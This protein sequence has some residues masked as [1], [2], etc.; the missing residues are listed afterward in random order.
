MAEGQRKFSTILF[1]FYYFIFII[2]SESRL[3]NFHACD[4]LHVPGE[5]HTAYLGKRSREKEISRLT[6]MQQ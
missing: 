2:C 1:Y 5:F 4:Q 6:L 3:G